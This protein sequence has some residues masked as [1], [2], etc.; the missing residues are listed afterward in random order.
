MKPDRTQNLLLR[1]LHTLS[2]RSVAMHALLVALS[3]VVL[4]PMLWMRSPRTWIAAART[5]RCSSEGLPSALLLL[6]ECP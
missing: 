1:P 6:C 4:T 5:L 2:P 3:V